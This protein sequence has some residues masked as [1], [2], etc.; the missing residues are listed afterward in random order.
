M[1]LIERIMADSRT[2]TRVIGGV[3]WRP[4]DSL[5]SLP[6]GNLAPADRYIR[7]ALISVLIKHLACRHCMRVPG[8]CRSRSLACR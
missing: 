2:E 8:C 5:R 4:W 6:I 3:P 1:G 7:R